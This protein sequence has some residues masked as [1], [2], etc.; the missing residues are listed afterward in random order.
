MWEQISK[1]GNKLV[2]EGLVESHFGNISVRSNESIFITAKGCALDEIKEDNV[3]EVGLNSICENDE[4]ASSETIVHRLIY[5][6]SNCKAIIHA[7]CPFSVVE[8]LLVEENNISP[9]DSEG[10]LFL[11]SIPLI[12]GQIG[13]IELA[14]NASN[15]L[16]DHNAAIVRGHGTFATGADLREAYIITTQIEHSCRIKYWYDLAK[17]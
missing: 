3:I 9:L 8:S 2:N 7:H 6:N 1:F 5:Q 13:S 15:A 16:M 17:K 11:K 14:K 12:S 10:K 4:I